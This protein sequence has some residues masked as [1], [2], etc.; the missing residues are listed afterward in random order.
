MQQCA[1]DSRLGAGHGICLAAGT[2]GLCRGLHNALWSVLL[3]SAW[4]GRCFES[5][6]YL[7]YHNG[8]VPVLLLTC[9]VPYS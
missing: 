2:N 8:F 9:A 1:A 7:H 6:Q 5:F 3:L 4:R